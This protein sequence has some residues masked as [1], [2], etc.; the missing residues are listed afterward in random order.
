MEKRLIIAVILSVVVIIGFQVLFPQAKRTQPPPESVTIS[1]M[2]SE[3][4]P[5]EAYQE[6]AKASEK[7]FKK[8]QTAAETERYILT[9]TNRGGSLTGID[10]KDYT[11]S[12]ADSPLSLVAGAEGNRAVLAIESNAL[13]KGLATRNFKLVKKERD[14]VV[15]A[16]SVPGRFQI[17]KEY[18]LYNSHDYIVLRVFIKNLGNNTLYRDYDILGASGIKS[19]GLVMGRR[20]EEIDS[21]V[22]GKVMRTN[23]VKDGASFIKGIVSWTGVKERYFNVILK[24]QQD[25]EGVILKQ[26]D[27]PDLASGIRTKR[28]PIYPGATIEDSYVLYIGPNDL[29]RLGSLGFGLEQIVNY[30]IFGGISKFLLVVLR[31]FHKV[32]KN[33]GVAIIMLTFLI[34]LAL[35]P[36]TRKSFVSMRK[37]Q[38]VQPHIEK[39]RKVHKDNPQKLNKELA[40]L[41]RQ[42][43]V[44][45]F[46]GCLPLLIQMPI[47]IALYQ[48]LIRSI[49]LKGA[50]FLWIKDLATPDSVH[51]PFSLPFL[52]NQIH[53]LPLLMVIAMFLQQKISTKSS[54]VASK[55]QQQQQKFMLIFFPL[56]F[57]FLF[58]NFPSGLVLYWLTNTVLMVI[59]H[60]AMRGKHATAATA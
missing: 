26:F 47:F 23:K 44:N 51:L 22:D 6:A 57:G 30:G 19:T 29:A 32:V 55:E 2:G 3:S 53:L 48:G 54:P 58:Y 39:L 52:G 1:P 31:A 41:Y 46:G 37:I 8:R 14:K 4:L 12:R 16:Y 5:A 36:L 9:F 27:K 59:E 28:T 43:N 45:P 38:E 56:F 35:F 11:G 15:Y 25:S 34:N 40:E 13:A 21:M 50:S 42:Y 7:S 17:V 33:W 49:E 10:L 20:F 18:S 60:S 24:P